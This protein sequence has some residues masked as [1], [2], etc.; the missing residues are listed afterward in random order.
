MFLSLL[1]SKI[2]QPTSLPAEGAAAIAGVTP[3]SSTIMRVAE[4][5]LA[6]Q[7]GRMSMIEKTETAR[8]GSPTIIVSAPT[9]APVNNNVTGPTNISNQR[10]TAVGNGSGG[11][12]LAR[13]AN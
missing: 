13:F 1:Q 9:V 12:G 8:S 11:S 2:S 3:S 10:V 4:S 6:A 5:T 7:Q